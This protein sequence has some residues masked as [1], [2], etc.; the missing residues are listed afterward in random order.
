MP[1]VV[2]RNEN[3]VLKNF[4]SFIYQWGAQDRKFKFVQNLLNSLINGELFSNAHITM[5]VF[6]KPFSQ[7]Y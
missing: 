1:K 3:L 4:F 7:V 5:L 2:H 6:N